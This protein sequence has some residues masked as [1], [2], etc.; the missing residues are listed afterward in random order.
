MLHCPQCSS[1]EVTSTSK[2]VIMI[3]S[4]RYVTEPVYMHDLVAESTCL[5]CKWQGTYGDLCTLLYIDKDLT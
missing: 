2:Q 3:N 5:D 1:T 4:G